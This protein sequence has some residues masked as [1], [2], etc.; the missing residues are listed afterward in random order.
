MIYG[1]ILG[2]T[3]IT[4]GFTY[5][6]IPFYFVLL[7]GLVCMVV[8]GVIKAGMIEKLK[9]VLTPT[10]A[11]PTTPSPA[12]P[13]P[14]APAPTAKTRR[15]GPWILAA[16]IVLGIFHFIPLGKNT[17]MHLVEVVKIDQAPFP[18]TI[19]PLPAGDY[20]IKFQPLSVADRAYLMVRFPNG[21]L[22]LK[23]IN[24]DGSASLAE[25]ETA[26]GIKTDKKAEASV[27]AP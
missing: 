1:I 20:E 4:I 5:N 25:G 15:L 2:I 23:K 13:A 11:T 7:L 27:Y 8:V 22:A 26:I 3:I 6:L 18:K 9:P 12:A 21:S 14:T 10:P 17:Q 19:S 16:L 24:L